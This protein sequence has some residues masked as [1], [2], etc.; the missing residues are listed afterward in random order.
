M[1]VAGFW[2]R[3]GGVQRSSSGR[4]SPGS[5][6]AT[7]AT[8]RLWTCRGF[9]GSRIW[10]L[11][12]WGIGFACPTA[13]HRYITR[14]RAR[15]LRFLPPFSFLSYLLPLFLL[16]PFLSPPSLLFL[17]LSSFYI[18][19][20]FSSVCFS[21]SSSDI[22]LLANSPGKRRFLDFLNSCICFFR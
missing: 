9:S 18:L 15:S 17:F 10:R 13:E 5:C 1:W 2:C 3:S 12:A 21:S 11:S 22:L 19:S 7:G 8:A 6:G 4:A 16:L 20:S 14:D